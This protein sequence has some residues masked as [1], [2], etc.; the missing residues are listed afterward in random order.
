MPYSRSWYQRDGDFL[1]ALTPRNAPSIDITDIN[2]VTLISSFMY[3]DSIYSH[4]IFL[5]VVMNG[6][7]CSVN[8]RRFRFN[9]VSKL[10]WILNFEPLSISASQLLRKLRLVSVFITDAIHWLVAWS[11]YRDMTWW[12]WKFFVHRNPALTLH[13]HQWYQWRNVSIYIQPTDI[14]RMIFLYMVVMVRTYIVASIRDNLITEY[15]RFNAVSNLIWIWI[16]GLRQF[17]ILIAETSDRTVIYWRE[18]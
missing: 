2:D 12:C 9:A 5:M 3:I 15:F 11:N 7:H 16:I 1:F 17:W 4:K 13:W 6:A 8:L 14:T 18:Q 10:I